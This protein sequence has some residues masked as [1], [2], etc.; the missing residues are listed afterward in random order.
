ME[1]WQIWLRTKSQ[2][3]CT[4]LL[5]EQPHLAALSGT[6]PKESHPKWIS[7]IILLFHVD[8]LTFP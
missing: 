4:A 3:E 7:R 5:A 6:N 8:H 1:T 2:G